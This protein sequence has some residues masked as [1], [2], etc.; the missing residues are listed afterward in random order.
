MSKKREDARKTILDAAVEVIKE[1]GA[2]T[3]TIDRVAK[4]AGC[5]KGLVH[6]HFKTKAGMLGAVAD[7]LT[8]NRQASWT[9]AFDAPSPKDAIDQ[10]WALLSQESATGVIR[11]WTS[12]FQAG[13]LPEAT[14]R[15]AVQGLGRA[16][17]DA[18]MKLMREIDLT[19]TIPPA[20]I[21]WLLGAVVH[22]MGFQLASQEAGDD[23][24]GAYAAG[25]LGILSLF[26]PR[27][28]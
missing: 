23:L 12:L 2:R 1:R 22:G 16:L 4:R 13:V 7:A 18:T 5:A 27:R 10:T 24:E 3:V 9:A 15:D 19:P 11:A 17:G 8:A 14:V 6:Y 21:G 26:V 28:R 25:W 20:E